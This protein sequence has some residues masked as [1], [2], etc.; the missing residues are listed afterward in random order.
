MGREAKRRAQAM[1]ASH[2]DLLGALL[3]LVDHAEEP[4]P[5]FESER[6]KMDLAQAHAALDSGLAI[7]GKE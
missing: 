3:V 7:T 5:H 1:A 4:Y 2:K 6:G